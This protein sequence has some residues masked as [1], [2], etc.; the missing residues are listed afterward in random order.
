MV[1]RRYGAAF[2]QAVATGRLE[3]TSH[4]FR[5]QNRHAFLADDVIAWIEARA[6]RGSIAHHGLTVA[7]ITP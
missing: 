2:S 6:Q 7:A 5:I 4:G 1:E 3:R